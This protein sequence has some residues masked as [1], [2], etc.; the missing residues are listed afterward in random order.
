MNKHIDFT[1]V[2]AQKP[3]VIMGWSV[4]ERLLRRLPKSLLIEEFAKDYVTED[5]WEKLSEETIIHRIFVE[6]VTVFS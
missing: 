6:F 5:D 3:L 1:I 2:N 4:L